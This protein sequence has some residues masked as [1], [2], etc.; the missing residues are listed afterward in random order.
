MVGQPVTNRYWSDLWLN[1]G[2]TTYVEKRVVEALYGA[3]RADLERLCSI[4][5]CKATWPS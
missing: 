5:R 4:S 1:E 2:F 3:D